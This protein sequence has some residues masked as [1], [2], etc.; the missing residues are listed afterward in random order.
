MAEA[1]RD[2]PDWDEEYVDRVADRLVFNY[3]LEKDFSVRGE[4][5]DLYGRMTIESQKH[6]FHPALSYGNHGSAEHL[7]CRRTDRITA[8]D[9]ERLVALGHELAKEY[10]DA[11]EEHYSTD[12]TFVLLVPEIPDEVGEFVSG[13]RDRTLLKFGYYGH[14]EINLLVVAPDREELVASREAHLKEAFRLWDPIEK[15]EPGLLD[16]IARRLQ[17]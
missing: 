1:R 10:I 17:I 9:C 11:D 8:A 16:L 4:R 2:A 5:F 3:D 6:F 15:E 13:F 7:F 14:Y 12:F